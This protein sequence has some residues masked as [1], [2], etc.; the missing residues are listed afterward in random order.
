MADVG[1]LTIKVVADTS[2]ADSAARSIQQFK[3]QLDQTTAPIQRFANENRKL[4][5]GL[6]RVHGAIRT[7]ADGLRTFGVNGVAA[8]NDAAQFAEG[9]SSIIGIS[10]PI[11][12]ALT[13][14]AGVTAL[15]IDHFS[16]ASIEAKKFSNALDGLSKDG[17]IAA[18]ALSIVL[19]KLDAISTTV[20]NFK[21]PA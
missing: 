14:V 17:K 7:A 8:A 2:G 11:G 18:D 9:L 6:G 5:E 16:G 20:S 3:L 10:G 21:L 12:L 15:L 13:A 19:D 4:G 1:T